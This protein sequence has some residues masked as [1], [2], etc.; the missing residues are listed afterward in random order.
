M[1]RSKIARCPYYK[2]KSIIV[3]WNWF[4]PVRQQN[5]GTGYIHECWLCQE[6]FTTETKVL[7]GVP[8]EVL[9]VLLQLHEA[10]LPVIYTKAMDL[11]YNNNKRK[12]T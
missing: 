1:A 10:G 12:Q 6:C 4:G 9:I 8:Y 5:G 7:N 3:C 11:L 2:C